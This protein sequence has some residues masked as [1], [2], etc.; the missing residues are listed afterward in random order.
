MKRVI[1]VL[2]IFISL[3]GGLLFYQWVGYSSKTVGV[4]QHI[5][6]TINIKHTDNSFK[7]EQTITGVKG[8]QYTIKVPTEANNIRCTNNEVE[9]HI[10][11]SNQVVLQDGHVMFLYDLPSNKDV[12]SLLLENYSIKLQEI[13]VGST[14]VQLSDSIW[15]NG[16]WISTSEIANKRKLDLVDYYVIENEGNEPVLYWQAE[17]LHRNEV[18]KNFIVYSNSKI[19]HD[20]FETK[21]K[22]PNQGKAIHIVL[23]NLH[24][25]VEKQNFLILSTKRQPQEIKEKITIAFIYSVFNNPTDSIRIT[26]IISSIILN[27]PIGDSKS[28]KIYK[29]MKDKLTSDELN[30][31]KEKVFDLHQRN[32]NLKKLDGLLEEVTGFKSSFFKDNASTKEKLLPMLLLDARELNIKGSKVDD[33]KIVHEK[34][35]MMIEFVPLLEA[36]QYEVSLADKGVVKAEKG[37]IKYRFYPNKRIFE[38]NNQKYGMSHAPIVDIDGHA[39]IQMN[40][41]DTLLNV[42]I[43]E[44]ETKIV[45]N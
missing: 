40:I 17:P 3:I 9:C 15:R 43:T 32:I 23:S 5:E 38:L 7:V 28:I 34:G 4:N 36:L 42:K 1:F 27:K 14:K 21:E 44:N 29:E 25:E 16:N 8:K 26:D 12:K 31:W 10:Q 18:N 22:L 30:S 39:Y 24:E 19:R 6:Q 20:L 37:A 33:V 11:T 41:V 2:I 13:E 35:I 45:L